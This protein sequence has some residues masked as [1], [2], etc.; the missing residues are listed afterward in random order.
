MHRR[1]FIKNTIMA[2]GLAVIYPKSI[3]GK[4]GSV[5]DGYANDKVLKPYPAGWRNDRL[6]IAWI[7]HSTVLMNFFGKIILTDPVLFEKIG[8][9]VWGTTIGQSRYSP[10][11][12]SFDEIPQPDVVLLSH[13]HMDH[14]DY[15]SLKALTEKYS[16]KID[17][18][19]AYNTLDVAGDLNWKSIKEMDWNDEYTLPGFSFKA[20]RVK[21]FGWRYPWEKDRSKGFMKDGRSF[22]AYLIERNGKTVLFGGDTALQDYFAADIG[23]KA[24]VAIMPVGAYNPWRFNHCSPDEALKMA[25]AAGAGVFIPIH[26]CTFKQGIEPADEPLKLVKNNAAKFNMHIGI[27]E[28]GGTFTLV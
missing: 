25:K 17:C 19:T 1:K 27:E 5:T 11:A 26:C 24:D 4:P 6:T 9:Y 2:A 12:L 7:G 28:L 15:K 13:A 3:W 16:G 23:S 22:N 10:P 8:I 20:L 21:H 18:I 14:T